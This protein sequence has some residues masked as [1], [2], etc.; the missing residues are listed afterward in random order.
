MVWQLLENGVV[1]ES[2]REDVSLAPQQSKQ[3]IIHSAHEQQPGALYHI[4]IQIVLKQSCSWA[5]SE[6]EMMA[7]QFAVTNRIGLA[8][9]VIGSSIAESI[10]VVES[11]TSIQVKVN[12]S[13]FEVS[14]ESS[15]GSSK[16]VTVIET[17]NPIVIIQPKSIIGLIPLNINDKKAQTVVSTV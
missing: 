3:Y 16:N 9:T 15:E 14:K 6:H 1:V 17:V 4:N 7:E 8:P 2:G 11:E 12:S 13:T 5:Q 10:N